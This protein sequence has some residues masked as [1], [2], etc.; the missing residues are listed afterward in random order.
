MLPAA[1]PSVIRPERSM[2][3]GA[4][5]IWAVPKTCWAQLSYAA[6][7][8]GCCERRSKSKGRRL[9]RRGFR[10]N[11]ADL[12]ARLV[13]ID[14]PLR[15]GRLWKTAA[16]SVAV[17]GAIA[18]L[19]GSWRGPVGLPTRW[20]VV[21]LTLSSQSLDVERLAACWRDRDLAARVAAIS[22]RAIRPRIRRWSI[23]GHGR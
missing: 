16:L 20:R 11:R 10:S 15:T 14:A 4:A 9:R 18:L 13:G 5:S 2:L 6:A 7:A 19:L 21:D 3:A 1:T 17:G 23:G 22:Q 12:H 8:Q